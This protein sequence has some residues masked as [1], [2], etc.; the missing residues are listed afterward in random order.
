MTKGIVINTEK[1]LV[2]NTT[3]KER[4][5]IVENNVGMATGNTNKISPEDIKF[6]NMY[7]EGEIELSEAIDRS[8]QQ[9]LKKGATL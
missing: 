6:L 5:E 3:K 9:Y 7:I 2:K 8:K 4:K 1:L